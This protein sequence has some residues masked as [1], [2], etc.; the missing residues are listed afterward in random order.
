MAFDVINIRR[1][2]AERER[3]TQELLSEKGRFTEKHLSVAIVQ[4]TC[5]SNSLSSEPKQNYEFT[6]HGLLKPDCK[7]QTHT[8]HANFV[9][10]KGKLQKSPGQKKNIFEHSLLSITITSQGWWSDSVQSSWYTN[11]VGGGTFAG[12]I[13]PFSNAALSLFLPFVTPLLYRLP[14]SAAAI[15]RHTSVLVGP[16]CMATAHVQY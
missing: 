5:P 2:R 8:I 11:Q 9:N 15:V 16:T 14:G 7:E 4:Q 10:L 1:N 13:N 12:P 6:A 3:R